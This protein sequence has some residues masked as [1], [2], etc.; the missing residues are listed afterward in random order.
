M[1]QARA[2][3]AMMTFRRAHASLWQRF[4]DW[5]ARMGRAA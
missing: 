4:L 1:S 3:Y 2:V 5:C